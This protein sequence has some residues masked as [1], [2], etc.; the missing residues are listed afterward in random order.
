MPHGLVVG[1]Q[2]LCVSLV[3]CFLGFCCVPW[4]H[5]PARALLHDPVVYHVEGGLEWV[6][7]AQKFSRPWLTTL[8][9]WLSN[10]VGVPFYVSFLNRALYSALL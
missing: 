7:W 2:G 3:G 1:F 4:L 10:T 8:F 9:N 6:L 5:K